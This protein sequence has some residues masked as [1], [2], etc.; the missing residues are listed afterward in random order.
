M[1]IGK[2]LRIIACFTCTVFMFTTVAQSAPIVPQHA[3]A[4]STENARDLAPRPL[5][6]VIAS[7]NK[8]IT[9]ADDS[10]KA[11]SMALGFLEKDA[12][13]HSIRTQHL[14]QQ[15]IPQDDD[16]YEEKIHQHDD[17]TLEAKLTTEA[18][19]A[20]LS[21]SK[22]I[23]D[24]L[25]V[26]DD[27]SDD[28]YD[29]MIIFGSGDMQVPIA[30]AQLYRE[31]KKNIKRLIIVGGGRGEETEAVVYRRIMIEQGVA[32]QDIIIPKEEEKVKTGSTD[33]KKN[34]QYLKNELKRRDIPLD[35][36]KKVIVVQNPFV[37][38]RAK[39]ITRA[40]MPKTE[41]CIRFTYAPS[42]EEVSK[43]ERFLFEI[44]WQMK[45]LEEA[46]FDRYKDDV[47]DEERA[48]FLTHSQRTETVRAYLRVLDHKNI[49][50]FPIV[51]DKDSIEKTSDSKFTNETG[52]IVLRMLAIILF[53]AGFVGIVSNTVNLK[54]YKLI[55]DAAVKITSNAKVLLNTI[56]LDVYIYVGAAFLLLSVFLIVTSI[57][58][59]KKEEP[60]PKELAVLLNSK[61]AQLESEIA[62]RRE[63]N[64]QQTAHRK[65]AALLKKIAHGDRSIKSFVRTV[66]DSI[67]EIQALEGEDHAA[68][69]AR[70]KELLKMVR[71]QHEN[72]VDLNEL[73]TVQEQI[74][75]AQGLLYG[76]LSN[77]S[78]RALVEKK[79]GLAHVRS[80]RT[81]SVL[82]QLRIEE[83]VLV[84]LQKKQS[85]KVAAQKRMAKL[86]KEGD[87]V[88][89]ETISSLL[90]DIGVD[91]TMWY[92]IPS[93]LSKAGIVRNRKREAG[94]KFL[95]RLHKSGVFR[96]EEIGKA[97]KDFELRFDTYPGGTLRPFYHDPIDSFKAFN[98]LLE[99]SLL[100]NEDVRMQILN[101]GL[102]NQLTKKLLIH[103]PL[104]ELFKFKPIWDGEKLQ[105]FFL[106]LQKAGDR[107]N[108]WR[109]DS[110]EK[111]NTF[112]TRET[113][114]QFIN[115][116]QQTREAEI[117]SEAGKIPMPVM[118]GLA[119]L[120][121]IFLAAVSA[122]AFSPQT[123][124]NV[125]TSLVPFWLVVFAFI[126]NMYMNVETGLMPTASQLVVRSGGPPIWKDYVNTPIEQIPIDAMGT[127]ILKLF[128]LLKEKWSQELF[129]CIFAC[130]KHSDLDRMPKDDA[131]SII[132]ELI[133]RG[134]YDYILLFQ[135]H[136]DWQVRVRVVQSLGYHAA[137]YEPY[138]KKALHDPDLR[139][140]NKARKALFLPKRNSA[141]P[142]GVT[143]IQV[144]EGK[145]SERVKTGL[146]RLAAL[147]KSSDIVSIGGMI[148]GQPYL[149]RQH[150]VKILGETQRE[151][152]IIAMPY[153]VSALKDDVAFVWD[154]AQKA[155]PKVLNSETV[156]LA[157]RGLR[158][159]H[160]RVR[161]IVYDVLNDVG[162]LTDEM[163][164]IKDIKDLAD[165]VL[166]DKTLQIKKQL[167]AFGE[168][169]VPELPALVAIVVDPRKTVHIRSA[170]I[171]IMEAVFKK[172]E[173][174]VIQ[175]TISDITQKL[176][177]SHIDDDAAIKILRSHAWQKE[178]PLH[179]KTIRFIVK[180]IK[181]YELKG[182]SSREWL[183]RSLPFKI[184]K[185]KMFF[186]VL[187][188]CGGAIFLIANRV[189]P[190]QNSGALS[191]AF[192]PFPFMV[193]A[194]F[195]GV[196]M[197]ARIGDWS[198]HVPP[199]DKRKEIYSSASDG[200]IM[201]VVLSICALIGIGIAE[202]RLEKTIVASAL[203]L[204]TIIGSTIL[205][206]KVRDTIR[207]IKKN[208]K[209]IIQAFY[210]FTS[211][212]KKK[213]TDN[214]YIDVVKEKIK[215]I[216]Y[217]FVS[218]GAL[219]VFMFIV[220]PFDL[221]ASN[222]TATMDPFTKHVLILAGVFSMAAAVV[223]IIYKSLT[224]GRKKNEIE[225]DT[226]RADG[227]EIPEDVVEQVLPEPKEEKVKQPFDKK[228]PQ[229]S[230]IT[231]ERFFGLHTMD[232]D[233]VVKAAFQKG[234]ER[235]KQIFQN[236]HSVGYFDSLA[237]A[238]LDTAISKLGLYSQG[239][240]HISPLATKNKLV[241]EGAL[242]HEQIHH[243]LYDKGFTKHE[244]DIIAAV[245]EMRYIFTES[246]R[247]DT[248][249]NV[250]LG[251]TL[252]EMV[253]FL[254]TEKHLALQRLRR[255]LVH[256]SIVEG[257]AIEK[258]IQTVMPIAR[259]AHGDEKV[260]LDTKQFAKVILDIE[261]KHFRAGT[262][263]NRI[264]TAN[265]AL[266]MAANNDLIKAYFEQES[267]CAVVLYNPSGILVPEIIKTLIHKKRSLYIVRRESNQLLT[268]AKKQ[269]DE[270]LY[271]ISV[272][273]GDL[274]EERIEMVQSL[275]EAVG[276]ISCFVPHVRVISS[277]KREFEKLF[278]SD[279]LLLFSTENASRRLKEKKLTD[280]SPEL[281]LL[282]FVFTLAPQTLEHHEGVNRLFIKRGKVWELN[283]NH[284]AN[285][286]NN[287]NEA[288]NT[289]MQS[290]KGAL[291]EAVLMRQIQTA[292]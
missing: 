203:V 158:D 164:I 138:I 253:T 232:Q 30:A 160:E 257:S 90:K 100:W 34:F 135:D 6:E 251:T 265:N 10:Q 153:L 272:V 179:K 219:T 260:A 27:M 121:T 184:F 59:S 214:K 182:I 58:R 169:I 157:A 126:V 21:A 66:D 161:R 52:S 48:A 63:E 81:L 96:D 235:R 247:I 217:T 292:A 44:A 167:I 156:P 78:T 150:A 239:V 105:R 32:A 122:A 187:F 226:G 18:Y 2:T 172:T 178:N 270:V 285:F 231:V 268:K 246:Y 162:A 136:S 209:E 131:Q 51:V 9:Q 146:D 77:D 249:R 143:I 198:N 41:K 289:V 31:H 262:F 220:R 222:G 93:L 12:S 269:Y 227:E 13:G 103:R 190:A 69:I 137:E 64:I 175:K 129:D 154:S 117:S 284:I 16:L 28:T 8:I 54:R 75:E 197:I 80:E 236:T 133:D 134:Q 274:K 33:F 47:L 271:K 228:E 255:L 127:I 67:T 76:V 192:S 173:K 3:T 1:K 168:K 224:N 261:K 46:L 165:T 72:I 144:S 139:V 223:S 20:A 19:E 82:Y 216:L 159:N 200:I 245:I 5:S 171:E 97:G 62:A 267:D 286:G 213:I 45:N 85:L 110:E 99:H 42:F 174:S 234:V 186:L 191:I 237:F 115:G 50:L 109:W 37:I 111:A 166:H 113:I 17:Y 280:I 229:E 25:P 201:F 95:T 195:V 256:F 94:K 55:H 142:L 241:L 170:G 92:D 290:I 266:L 88:N 277:D 106:A 206:R 250:P 254:K 152:R 39:I 71:E 259:M 176:V 147:E 273:D 278:F 108:E 180:T 230:L 56:P 205:I 4:V 87:V 53:L 128:G 291:T 68:K 89:E 148:R 61:E 202:Y 248:E 83:T 149:V 118:I 101:I 163:Q 225:S 119:V 38:R 288:F 24:Y 14:E 242:V 258:Q 281:L 70:L 79:V 177:R 22:D 252:H 123:T 212:L 218:L 116:R 57:I 279:N 112:R 49:D 102:L 208:K 221:F 104:L 264:E 40:S 196:I 188:L 193:F 151:D 29:A 240:V 124:E 276:Y 107:A 183:G 84:L 130:L 244:E 210:S 181:A 26:I 73:V 238:C 74:V 185:L 98:D 233:P 132:G 86:Q 125:V 11:A 215:Q 282:P 243:I 263:D 141:K 60:A 207:E 275:N 287:L 15:G 189:W 35:E 211:S 194:V 155:L 145:N 120:V 23:L 7:L 283:V 91:Q 36:L 199:E 114:K 65:I 140:S 204:G 43:S